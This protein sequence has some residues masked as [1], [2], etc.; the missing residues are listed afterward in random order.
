ME[1]NLQVQAKEVVLNGEGIVNRCFVRRIQIDSEAYRM[2][3]DKRFVS[4]KDIGEES[5]SVTFRDGSSG[6][7]PLA[8]VKIALFRVPSESRSCTKSSRGHTS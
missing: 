7:Y 2:V 1:K 8:N 6:E 4:S 3:A 5:V